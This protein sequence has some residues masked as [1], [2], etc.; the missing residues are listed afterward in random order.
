MK[1]AIVAVAYNRPQSLKRLLSSL[2]KAEYC[3][4]NIPLI[5]S[6]DWQNSDNHSETVR[7]AD[8]FEWK[9]G[10]KRIIEHE[11]NLGLRTHILKC[12]ELLDI[13][14]ATVILEDD[15]VVSQSFYLYTKATIDR[16]SDCEDIAGISLYSFAVNYQTSKPFVP[17]NN[18]YDVYFMNCAQS[19]GQIWMKKQ[20]KSFIDW[21]SDNN[22]RITSM[23]HLPEAIC[24]WPESS[25]LKYH[26]K[27]C[28]EQ[29]KYFVYPYISFS[30]NSG[31]SGTHTKT[32]SNIFQVPMVFGKKV[33]FKFPDSINDTV[34]YDGFFENKSISDWF[35][36]DKNSICV[37]LNDSIKN[38][39]KRF[40]LSTDCNKP[41]KIIQ[42]FGL[43]VRPIEA[44]IFQQTE[45]EEIFL[46]DTHCF[47]NMKNCSNNLS[48]FLYRYSIASISWLFHNLNFTELISYILKSLTAKIKKW[49]RH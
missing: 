44:N 42:S 8:N 30:T 1:T 18:G 49:F 31:D 27:Y 25:W 39:D 48:L 21:Y 38:T 46:Y 6:I 16:Y 20:W 4:E 32:D 33:E 35:Q 40:W 23:P 10:E 9:Y 7:V 11:K 13:F 34:C 5:I 45:G 19:W 15:I 36:M 22:T 14:D 43:S 47:S 41:Y 12:G 37:D 28:I 24:S 2:D 17:V 3:G 26:T 29:D